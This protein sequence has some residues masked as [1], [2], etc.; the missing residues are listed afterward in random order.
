ML[1]RTAWVSLVAVGVCVAGLG[2]AAANSH[3]G[4]GFGMRGHFPGH[5][6]PIARLIM[7]KIGR[8]M[9]LK[10]E[11]GVTDEQR[12]KLREIGLSHRSEAGPA[13]A[14]VSASF[15]GLR[16]AVLAESGDEAA[17]R[18]AADD[19]GKAVGDLAVVLSKMAKEGREVLTEDQRG[20]IKSFI[21]QND[22]AADKLHQE[23]KAKLEKK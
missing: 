6:G 9:V 13:I 16:D 20:Q 17:I 21:A 10:S 14:K 12:D 23:M 22:A 19:H 18:K 15:R 11:L 4:G 2:A 7:G 3:H 8:L 1:S 5:D